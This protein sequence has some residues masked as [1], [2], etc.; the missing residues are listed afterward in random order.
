MNECH[1]KQKARSPEKLALPSCWRIAG[2]LLVFVGLARARAEISPVVL[3]RHLIGGIFPPDFESLRQLWRV[4]ALLVYALDVSTESLPARA[5]S[6]TASSAS[7]TTSLALDSDGI[8]PKDAILGLGLG[9]GLLARLRPGAVRQRHII[10][11]NQLR[12]GTALAK[13]PGENGDGSVSQSAQSLT[14]NLRN[15]PVSGLDI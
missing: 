9:A 5:P 3:V 8:L 15:C 4:A 11:P 14:P 13:Q 12:L 1:S 2:S 7:H 6:S 10:L